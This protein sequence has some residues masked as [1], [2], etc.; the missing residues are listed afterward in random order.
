MQPRRGPER[1]DQDPA[2][3]L[4]ARDAARREF[5]IAEGVMAWGD[6]GWAGAVMQNL[7]ENAGSSQIN[8]GRAY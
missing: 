5:A 3:D 6:P 1:D 2:A 4:K 8:T 7:L